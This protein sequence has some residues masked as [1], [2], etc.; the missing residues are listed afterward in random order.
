VQKLACN[1]LIGL[2]YV[3]I[4]N[5]FFKTKSTAITRNHFLLRV[6]HL[7]SKLVKKKHMTTNRHVDYNC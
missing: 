1:C 3:H 7:S 4:K 6:C 2:G 5:D